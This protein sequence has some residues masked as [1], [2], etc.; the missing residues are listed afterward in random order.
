MAVSRGGK[1]NN[2]RAYLTQLS[3]SL[4]I[5]LLTQTVL[6]ITSWNITKPSYIEYVVLIYYIA[7]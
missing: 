5:Y 2:S 1:L 3:S 6:P 4:P 7:V